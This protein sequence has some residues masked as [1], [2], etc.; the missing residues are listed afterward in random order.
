[1]SVS[2][3]Q[4]RMYMVGSPSKETTKQFQSTFYF[5]IVSISGVTQ[6]LAPSLSTMF[7]LTMRSIL[8]YNFLRSNGWR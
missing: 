8:L 6:A 1:M 3:Q 4:K 5:V 2:I 7:R